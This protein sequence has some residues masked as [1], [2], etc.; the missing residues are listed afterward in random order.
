VP[1]CVRSGN[2]AGGPPTRHYGTQEQM[3]GPRQQVLH[4]RFWLPTGGAA[5][6]R[7]AG[8]PRL[9]LCGLSVVAS[10]TDGRLKI[11]RRASARPYR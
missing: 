1:E 7:C 2:R 11:A 3:F 5:A 9:D 8:S 10:F 6:R 4:G